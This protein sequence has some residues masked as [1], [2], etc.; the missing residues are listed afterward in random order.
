MKREA[1]DS[2]RLSSRSCRCEINEKIIKRNIVA[3]C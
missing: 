1:A 3:I 2:D